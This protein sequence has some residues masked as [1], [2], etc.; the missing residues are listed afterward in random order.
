MLFFGG[1]VDY[2]QN[3]TE[4]N[5]TVN[6]DLT[7]MCYQRNPGHSTSAICQ[8]YLFIVKTCFQIESVSGLTRLICIFE[9]E[10]HQHLQYQINITRSIMEYI[11]ILDYLV[12]QM[13][14]FSNI[15]LVPN[16]RNKKKQREYKRKTNMQ[17]LVI[18]KH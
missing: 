18:F 16:M 17:L 12:L 15:N 4:C 9:Q 1:T 13:L 14:I 6:L 3:L 8:F 5:L 2:I 10:K 7:K 11:F